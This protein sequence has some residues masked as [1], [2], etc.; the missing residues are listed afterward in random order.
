MEAAFAGCFV[1]AGKAAE[2]G[3]DIHFIEFK[4]LDFWLLISAAFFLHTYSVKKCPCQPEGIA[5]LP[6][7]TPVDH[8]NIHSASSSF[9]MQ[10]FAQSIYI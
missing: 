2:T 4:V 1:P 6:L 10:C 9:S 8:Q 5:S 3:L 7:G